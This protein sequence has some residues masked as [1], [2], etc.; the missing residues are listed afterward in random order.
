[1]KDMTKCCDLH[2][3]CYGTCNNDKDECDLSF[4]KC[5]YKLCDSS[6][7][8]MTEILLTGKI[9]LSLFYIVYYKVPLYY[10]LTHSF[11]YQIHGSHPVI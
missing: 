6:K 11:M 2:D 4:K 5:L 7:K 3:I 10:W 1:M 8:G 9:Y